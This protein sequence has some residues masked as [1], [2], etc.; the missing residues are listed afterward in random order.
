MLYWH[1]VGTGKTCSAIATA[2]NSFELDNYTILWVTRHT[3]KPDIW[4]NIYSQVCSATIKQK[5]EDGVQIPEVMTGN[6]L[7]YLDNKWVEPISYKQFSNLI[8]GKNNYYNE[9]VKRNGKDDPLRKT[10]IIIDE[11]HK[12]F[13]EDVPAN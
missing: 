7:K 8:A 12:I 4:K 3:L 9:L 11:A 10:F 1:S 5:L 6:F 13:A 2:S